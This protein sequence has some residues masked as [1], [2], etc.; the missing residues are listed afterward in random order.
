MPQIQTLLKKKPLTGKQTGKHLCK[1]FCKIDEVQV[2]YSFE[3]LQ[4]SL[5]RKCLPEADAKISRG[6]ILC[7]WSHMRLQEV[8]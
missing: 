4:L 5:Y 7:C 3:E 1:L 8:L 6:R 2:L